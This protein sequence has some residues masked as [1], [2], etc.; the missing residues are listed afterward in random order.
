MACKIMEFPSMARP[1]ICRTAQECAAVPR[2]LPIQV[3]LPWPPPPWPPGEKMRQALEKLDQAER[4][5]IRLAEIELAQAEKLVLT[6]REQLEQAY[7]GGYR[8]KASSLG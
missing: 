1:K 5:T 2:N 6:K 7:G 8:F 3:E 4:E